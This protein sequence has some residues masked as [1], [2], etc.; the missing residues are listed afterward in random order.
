MR[1]NSDNGY[2]VYLTQD[3]IRGMMLEKAR[4]PGLECI[5]QM[6]GRRVGN[7]FYY[8]ILEASQMSDK[9]AIISGVGSGGFFV[10][11]ELVKVGIGSL[12]VADDDVFA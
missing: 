1:Q 5:I 10:G 8:D 11:L 4:H 3:P 7:N 12:I 9:Q 2:H 6:P